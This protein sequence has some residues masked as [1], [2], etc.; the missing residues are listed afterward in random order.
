LVPDLQLI[1][2][3]RTGGR[4]RVDG[5]GSV[6]GDRRIRCQ[7]NAKALRLRPSRLESQLSARR[8]RTL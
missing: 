2:G 8:P 3:P 1:G 5:L 6:M 7:T 4:D